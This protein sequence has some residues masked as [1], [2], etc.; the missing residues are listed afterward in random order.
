MAVLLKSI[1]TK[2]ILEAL[3]HFFS[4]V[5]LPLEVQHDRG[6]NFTSGGFQ[7]VMLMQQGFNKLCH[8]PIIL[9]LK[10]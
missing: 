9:S 6:S 5:C 8:L 3:L 1:K 7:E 4:R 2:V 10:V